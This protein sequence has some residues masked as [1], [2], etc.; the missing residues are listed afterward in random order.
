[1]ETT[2]IYVL[3]DPVTLEVRY[4]GKS[5]EPNKRLK[6]HLSKNKDIG[7][8]KRNWLNTLEDKPILEI[9][10]KVDKKNWAER[11]KFYINYYLSCGCKLVNWAD[12]GQ[13]LTYGNQTSF[14]KNQ[15]NRKIIAIE[16]NGDIFKVF[17]SQKILCESLNLIGG[18]VYNVLKKKRR[19][20]KGL[21]YLDY[22]EY[23]KMSKEE[24][25]SH[26]FW[27]NNY[28][29]KSKIGLKTRFKK[30]HKT[31]PG[32]IKNLTRPVGKKVEQLSLDGQLIK[33]WKSVSEASCELKI[34]SVNIY[35]VITEKRKTAGG[36]IWKYH[37]S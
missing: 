13:G 11:E 27:L 12:G 6:S 8:H 37:S 19:F 23:S 9:I 4:V 34:Q 5:N 16:K 28:S 29:D 36:F 20:Y 18:G 35:M 31:W 1:M 30:G 24:L 3:K 17:E 22:E 10:E 21:N 14:K 32:A 25:E 26:I 33:I 2:F 15:G 7:T